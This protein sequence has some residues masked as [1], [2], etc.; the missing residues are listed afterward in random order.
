MTGL[1]RC[2]VTGATG[3]IGGHLG[4]RLAREGVEVRCLAR[5]SSDTSGIEGLGVEIVTG[6]LRDQASVARAVSGCLTVFHCGALVSDWATVKEI[7][8]INVLGTRSLLQA[9]GAES[10]QRFVHFSTTDVYGYR[11]QE[12][13]DEAYTPSGFSNWYAQS[14]L[15]AEHEVL[16]SRAHGL[17]TV[18]LRPATV[19]GPRSHEVIG[20]IA[21]AIRRRD[22]L[23]ID[24]GRAVAGLCYVENVVDAALA[25]A[26]HDAAIGETFNVTDGLTVTWRQF[27]EDLARGLGCPPP[28]WSLPYGVANGIGLILERGYRGLRST[29]GLKTRPLLSRQAVHVLGAEQ[30]FSNEKLRARLGWEPRIGY[31]AGLESTLAW[32]RSSGA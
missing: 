23:L 21:R 25:A 20:D 15:A 11:G 1:G 32:L 29:T 2:L 10:V 22:M 12:T 3:F 30:R 16:E 5:A 24:K 26:G 13:I 28:R 7:T 19:Y 8:D 27:T 14:K 18:I 6:E 4:E 17:S 9:A 31:Q